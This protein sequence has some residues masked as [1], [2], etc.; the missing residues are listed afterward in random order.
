MKRLMKFGLGATGVALV[1]LPATVFAA[2]FPPLPPTTFYGKVTG[3]AVAGQAV[4]A[5]VSD[6]ASQAVCGD[7]A[8]MTSGSDLVYVIDII[9]DSQKSGCGKAGST[10]QFYFTPTG[11]SGG[12][13]ATGSF[14]WQAAGA[15]KNQDLSLGAALT[16]RATV[17]ETSRDGIY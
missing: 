12:R 13:V 8:V 7:G 14:A 17:P 16:A 10:I 11:G 9:S 2:D 5:I 6:G 4:V 3:G 15:P 1:A